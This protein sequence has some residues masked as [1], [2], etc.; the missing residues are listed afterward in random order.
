[1]MESR[2]AP[3][4]YS[5]ALTKLATLITK[6]HDLINVCMVDFVTKSIFENVVPLELKAN[7]EGLNDDQIRVLPEKFFN[8]ESVSTSGIQPIDKLI[9]ELR[10]HTLESLGVV[11]SKAELLTSLKSCH[12]NANTSIKYFDKFMSDKK[13]HEVV[14][15]S[16]VV[17]YL[18]C[19][20]H[21]KTLIDLGSGK[22]YLSQ[23]LSATSQ[24]LRILAIDSSEINSHGAK[25]R[26]DRLDSKWDALKKRADIRASG[27]DPPVRSKHA[28]SKKKDED[29]PLSNDTSEVEKRNRFDDNLKYATKF[30]D[31]DTNLPSLMREHFSDNGSGTGQIFEE[32]LGLIGLH[33]CG[34]L[35]ANS[36]KIWLKNDSMKMLCNVGCCYHHIDEEFYKNPYLSSEEI[37]SSTPSFPMSSH[38]KKLKY[39]LGR[40][41]RMIAAQPM[42]RLRTNKQLPNESLLWR[43]ILQHIL[44]IH[45]PDLHFANQQVGRIATKCQTFVEYVQKAFQKLKIDLLWNAEKIEQIYIQLSAKHRSQLFAF[46]QLRTLFGPLIEGLILLDRIV[47]INETNSSA[48]ATLVQLFDPV[49]SPRCYG[50]I[51]R[52]H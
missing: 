40:N 4:V 6:Y 16:E 14:V 30:V 28:R 52:K 33:T 12:L 25:K 50:I 17:D 9:S 41:A 22:A 34:N 32:K 44:L 10:E 39:Q 47:S 8:D 37:D 26:S 19:N 2:K 7:L 31:V 42:D 29:K 20:T 46:Y 35:A 49:I 24:N 1:M 5:S 13:M 48:E 3:V 51:A 21:V 27:S 23:V 18:R 11:R 43:S 38:L 15:M 36:I 45:L